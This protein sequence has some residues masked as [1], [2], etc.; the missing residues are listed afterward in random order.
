[1]DFLKKFWPHPFKLEKKVV[2]PFVIMLI[3]YVAVTVAASIISG[4]LSFV[5]VLGWIL[6]IVSW[7]VDLYCTA[8][9]VFSILK[10]VGVFKD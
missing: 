5:P 9:I 6:S 1:M 4:V 7:L 2:K 3:I 10:F 8:G